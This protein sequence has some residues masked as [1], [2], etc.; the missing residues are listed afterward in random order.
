VKLYF[1]FLLMAAVTVVCPGPG[2]VMTLTNALRYNM[3][4]TFAGI[5]GIAI[6]AFV[7]A[8]ISATSLGALLA[9][10]PQ[11]FSVVKYIGVAYLI[12]LGIR[13]WR[14]PAFKFK[15]Q[16]A[17]EVSF[18]RRIMEGV[19]LQLTNPN[20]ILFYLSVFPQFIDPELGYSIQF[21]SMVCTYSALI[22][23]IH[24]LY[25]I[26]ARRA[27]G[28]F[29]SELGGLAL[30]RVAGFTFILFGAVLATAKI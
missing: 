8:A 25:A 11:A 24:W 26:T 5:L 30:N 29:T 15:E 13:L 21:I 27:K 19:S 1:L 3:A 20:V 12:Y 6:G 10:S 16:P 7:V 17:H 18:V 28:W 9:T 4:G 14:A 22:V 23:I 2:V